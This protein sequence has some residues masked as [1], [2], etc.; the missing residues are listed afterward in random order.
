MNISEGTQVVIAYDF[1]STS[2]IAFERGIE[3]AARSPRHVLHVITVVDDAHPIADLP[4]SK[5]DYQYTEKVQARVAEKL[6]AA[7]AARAPDL[8]VRFIVHV[9][10]GKPAEEI[11]GLCAD[12]GAELVVVGSHG[13]R[14][15]DRLLFGSVSEAVVRGARCPVLV[16]RP[17]TY[18]PVDLVEVVEA[19]EHQRYVRPHRYSYDD[20]QVLRRSSDWTIW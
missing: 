4:T 1:S 18:P 16:V 7:F 6:T 13:F 19:T 10:I 17:K 8:A 14:G 5:V 9:R 15:V 20:G 11:L 2:E 12:V 3:L